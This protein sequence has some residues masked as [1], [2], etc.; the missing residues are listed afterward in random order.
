MVREVKVN[1]I[2]YTFDGYPRDVI[3]TEVVAEYKEKLEKKT[4]LPPIVVFEEG[5]RF[6]LAD[7]LHRLEA[8]KELKRAKI[9]AVIHIGGSKD[10]LIYAVGA[11]DRH[12]KR[13]TSKDKKKAIELILHDESLREIS[14]NA[15]A[16][17]CRVSWGTVKTVWEDSG[18]EPRKSGVVKKDEGKS[19]DGE[20]SEAPAKRKKSKTSPCRTVAA[21]SKILEPADTARSWFKAEF[22]VRKGG[23]TPLSQEKIE[24]ISEMLDDLHV[25]THELVGE[26]AKAICRITDTR[27]PL[28]VY[29]FKKTSGI[30]RNKEF[31]KKD[32]A[33]YTVTVG[34]G[35][36]HQC[37]Y[38]ST[39]VMNRT[40]SFFQK[41]HQ[42]SFTRGNAIVDKG[43]AERLKKAIIADKATGKITAK[44]KILF[45]NLDDGWAPEA[46]KYNLGRDVLRVLLG[47]TPADIRL[48]TKGASIADCLDEF[49]EYK[50]RIIVG[51][52]TGMAKDQD[53]IGKL[54]EPNASLLSE[55]YAALKKAKQKGFKTFGMLC[56]CL[57]GI[58]DTK[59]VLRKMF[60]DVLACGV[61]HI[62]LEPV[63]PRGQAMK[64]MANALAAGGKIKE[65]RI[66]LSMS[67][68]SN[69]S[70]Y[71]CDL[72]VNAIAVAK[73]VKA[74]DKLRI[75][76]YPS[77]LKGP[78]YDRLK[79]IKKGIIWL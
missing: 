64:N 23:K 20:K 28:N 7:G 49:K 18:L 17:M 76:L 36:G 33:K 34:L 21:L 74:L 70:K 66:A 61:E 38:C 1:A 78:E 63:N 8:H 40:N 59:P 19:K 10:A 68:D 72:I 32:L 54:I 9:A 15:I 22:G 56:P 51:L 53:E 25:K 58:S 44:D 41:I 5:T 75:L 16:N 69:W 24:E 47:N 65:A 60:K 13:R 57:P 77:H 42:T 55:R 2:D 12:G 67:N 14:L 79:K 37:A 11:N 30:I 27:A 3:D 29:S 4:Q 45:S 31:E 73:E 52:S 35:C 39:A 71:A 43:R 62:W 50:N 6:H 48:L 46:L 26:L